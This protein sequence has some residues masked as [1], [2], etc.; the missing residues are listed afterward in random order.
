[1]VTS[2]RELEE[3]LFLFTHKRRGSHAVLTIMRGADAAPLHALEHAG[4]GSV[5]SDEALRE[6]GNE[7][8]IP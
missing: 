7:P 3:D 8:V 5:C 6:W 4:S 2:V 1:M